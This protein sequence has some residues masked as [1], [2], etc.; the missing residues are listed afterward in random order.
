MVAFRRFLSTV[1]TSF[2]F[3]T[4]FSLASDALR[5]GTLTLVGGVPFCYNTF[6]T[7]KEL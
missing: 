4:V 2:H 6:T 1:L 5:T 3:L 7:A